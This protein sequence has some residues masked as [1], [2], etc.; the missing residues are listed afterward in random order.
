MTAAL[1]LQLHAGALADKLV[2]LSIRRYPLREQAGAQPYVC[3]ITVTAT[4]D[5]I[6]ET[7]QLG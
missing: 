4:F 3:D 6:I 1:V 5:V 7:R 2:M